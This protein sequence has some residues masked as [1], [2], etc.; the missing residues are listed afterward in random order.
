MKSFGTRLCV[1]SLVLRA[2]RLTFTDH[3]RSIHTVH[4][5]T[6]LARAAASVAGVA[7]L[8]LSASEVYSPYVGEAERAVRDLLPKD[9]YY[10]RTRRVWAVFIDDLTYFNV[11]M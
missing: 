5:Q 7:F 3:A 9:L 8:Y 2:V 1:K 4:S 10:E 11:Y 6:T